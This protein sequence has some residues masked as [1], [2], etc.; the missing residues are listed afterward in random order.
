[1]SAAVRRSLLSGCAVVL[2]FAVCGLGLAQT[3]PAS[4]LQAVLQAATP[5]S[6]P[7]A[8]SASPPPVPLPLQREQARQALSTA[9]AQ[10]AATVPPS[11]MGAE[12]VRLLERLLVVV[13]AR[14][15]ADGEADTPP[16]GVM[17]EAAPSAALTALQGPPPYA[18]PLIDA[19]RDER[20]ALVAKVALLDSTLTT[21]EA[22]LAR[23]TQARRTAEEA[24][25]LHGD[26]VATG[27][28]PRDAPETADREAVARL[29]LDLSE[30]ELL[31]TSRSRDNAR[32][33]RAALRTRQQRLET[34]IARVV[35]QQRFDTE[36]LAPVIDELTTR[37]EQVARETRG[38]DARLA[39]L[40]QDVA[41]TADPALLAARQRELGARRSARGVLAALDAIAQAMQEAWRQRAAQHEQ[42]SAESRRTAGERIT[43]ALT[44]LAARSTI[45]PGLVGTTRQA[46]RDQEQRLQGLSAN[47]PEL[48]AERAALQALM[49]HASLQERSQQATAS[50]TRL[51][52]RSRED[53]QMQT[54]ERDLGERITDTAS[55]FRD[56]LRGIWQ[57]ELFAATDSAIVDG[58][59]VSVHYGVTVGKSIGAMLLFVIGYWVA[60]QAAKLGERLLVRRFSVE[61]Q[62]ARVLRRWLLFTGAM[63]VLVLV[64]NLARIPLTVFAFLGGA[65]AIG[66]GFG[67]QNIIKNL[68]S[69][70]II[71]FE[72]KVR[73]G[74]IVTIGTVTGTVSAVD[75][76]A[77]SVRGFDGIEAIL[78]NSNLLENQVSN[79]TFPS[80]LLR[81]SVRVGIAYGSDPAKAADLVCGCAM[82]HE[83]V[84]PDPAP[85][86]LLDNF[87]DNALELNLLYWL[88]LPGPL[89]GPQVD[90]QLRFAIYEALRVAGIGIAFPQRDVHLDQVGPLRVEIEMPTSA[91]AQR[92]R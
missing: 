68:I 3:A 19:L 15:Q 35:Q 34:E 71:L 60:S 87:G 40:M 31:L 51:Y 78:P 18:V 83:R 57:Y 54:R 47:A 33:Q 24:L 72:R 50:L 20:D 85:Q 27:R 16:S 26:R 91:T 62:L 90:S 41:T 44:Q 38:N 4:P 70:V 76:R 11:S 8:P 92:Q 75:L 29:R 25:R 74:D 53:L 64:L 39:R 30:A 32:E 52:E 88:H 65:L 6:V 2:S 84:L 14:M 55:Q 28:E 81:R 17:V 82:A 69:G 12:R 63:A 5:A 77:T 61:P 37:R 89:S 56:L 7:T 49:L 36:D 66:I 45:E 1:M 13:E 86:V 46:V 48:A 58:Q 23:L 79:W 73:V 59:T 42:T 67:T 9:R 22:D 21:Q 10:V 80:P 43:Q